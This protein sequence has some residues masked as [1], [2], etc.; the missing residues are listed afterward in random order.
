MSSNPRPQLP[1][2]LYRYRPLRTTDELE[3]E[4]DLLRRRFI[5]LS[6]PSAFNDPFDFL[7]AHTDESAAD[8][9]RIRDEVFIA[10]L[11]EVRPD[12]PDSVPMWS[13]YAND[14]R[15]ICIQYP[16]TESLFDKNHE[17]IY[18]VRYDLDKRPE[19]GDRDSRQMI[20]ATPQVIGAPVHPQELGNPNVI[21][22]EI[23]RYKA[24]AWAYEKE[25]SY[26]VTERFIYPDRW[27]TPAHAAEWEKREIAEYGPGY[28]HLKLTP[29]PSLIVLG[30]RMGQET[31]IL[32]KRWF[33]DLDIPVVEAHL[34]KTEW[35]I[36][37]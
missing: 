23:T 3:R 13:H 37:F 5:W 25:W 35:K 11:S 36:E 24:P 9:Y 33:A 31:S 18:P 17:P 32:L 30:A 1:K 29:K 6:P 28:R 20:V 26:V 34:S 8:V 7:L 10:A 2:N 22:T 21:N 14:H 27:M 12:H 16:F 15:G 4:L 19:V